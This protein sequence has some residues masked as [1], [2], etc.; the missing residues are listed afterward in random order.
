VC[1][2]LL[3]VDLYLICIR[4]VL[5]FYEHSQKAISPCDSTEEKPVPETHLCGIP[6]R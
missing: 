2:Y 3:Q 4:L 5:S 6:I 1:C